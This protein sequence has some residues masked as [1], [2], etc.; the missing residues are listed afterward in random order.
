MT[1][2]S[3]FTFQVFSRDHTHCPMNSEIFLLIPFERIC[4]LADED[5]HF[6]QTDL[7]IFFLK[8]PTQQNKTLFIK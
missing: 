6:K 3:L 7:K 4:V 8:N 1:T 5:S 2:F